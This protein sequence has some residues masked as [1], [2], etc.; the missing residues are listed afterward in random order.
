[1]K[2][3][4]N[5]DVLKSNL[6][7]IKERHS[8]VAFLIKSQL[9]SQE[10]IDVLKN[11]KVYSNKDGK[12]P[13][14]YNDSGYTIIDAYDKREGLTMQ[15]AAFVKDKA[16]AIINFYC[17]NELIPTSE[18]INQIQKKISSLGY[19]VVSFGGSMMLWYDDISVD[20][21]R[22]GE[23]LYTGYS[24]VFNKY[25][26]ECQNPYEIEVDITK[27][28]AIGYIVPHGFLEFGGFTNVKPI[29]VNTDISVFHKSDIQS[30]NG[31]LLL[32]PDYFTLIKMAHNGKL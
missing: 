14:I 7:I 32:K 31:K 26:L 1:M 16:T 18:D 25:Y 12:Y 17:C 13:N 29:C 21:I 6:Q 4:F 15:E 20:E 28:T 3:R 22:I 23:A 5:Q 27:E 24:T 10:I 8:N 19:R 2:V 11:E 9:L 30:Q